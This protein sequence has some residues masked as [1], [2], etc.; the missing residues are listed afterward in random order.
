MSSML[1]PIV[2][3]N[4]LAENL[5]SI[6]TFL[7]SYF[8]GPW[9]NSILEA[10]VF[11]SFAITL[12]SGYVYK[13]ISNIGSIMLTNVSDI[14]FNS[15]V[16]G[17]FTSSLIGAAG[18]FLIYFGD[19]SADTVLKAISS[20][21]NLLTISKNNIDNWLDLFIKIY[22]YLTSIVGIQNQSTIDY[23]KELIIKY[24]PS[25]LSSII[26][27]ISLLFSNTTDTFS[28]WIS[29]YSSD[30]EALKKL[31]EEIS[32]DSNTDFSIVARIRL[33]NDTNS[34]KYL[35]Y[36]TIALNKL[37]ELKR[38]MIPQKFREFFK[39]YLDVSHIFIK[40][41]SISWT[42]K[43]FGLSK[44]FVQ[45]IIDWFKP[46]TLKIVG[47]KNENLNTICLIVGILTSALA[48]AYL[49]KQIY[50]YYFAVKNEKR[51]DD[52]KLKTLNLFGKINFAL[53][54]MFK[55][56]FPWII[57]DNFQKV[58]IKSTSSL[59]SIIQLTLNN[60]DQ[61]INKI[62]LLL[63]EYVN[64]I[65]SQN[66]VNVT[67]QMISE[68]MNIYAT[69]KNQYKN[70]NNIKVRDFIHRQIDS[71]LLNL[72]L[73]KN[74]LEQKRNG[75]K[76]TKKIPKFIMNESDFILSQASKKTNKSIGN[77]VVRSN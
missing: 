53:V 18:L 29:H 17:I 49:V 21:T 41:T 37:N 59:K 39:Y 68:Y 34:K 32:K 58:K 28:Q 50:D 27:Y 71:I 30:I 25:F 61:N 57:T 48:S 73:V 72:T 46:L 66:V 45:Q 13:P 1:S 4:F 10:N 47:E 56:I 9:S 33:A 7:I 54:D 51:I 31:Q 20:L 65:N 70:N 43:I 6:I 77:D 74:F 16:F 23:C 55:I 14:L 44:S 67:I 60:T 62:V 22:K 40:E 76:I 63:K 42:Q 35:E 26:N 2:F 12:I 15:N 38:N 11:S 36:R 64:K 24:I 8:Y 69:I 19:N 52:S 3:K 75:V 5:I